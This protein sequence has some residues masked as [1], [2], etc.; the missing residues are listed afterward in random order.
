MGEPDAY[1][2]IEDKNGQLKRVRV[3]ATTGMVPVVE[4]IQILCCYSHQD[5][6]KKTWTR[7][8]GIS[9]QCNSN[10]ACIRLNG[11][12]QSMHCLPIPEFTQVITRAIESSHGTVSKQHRDM[13]DLLARGHMSFVVRCSGCHN[14]WLLSPSGVGNTEVRWGRYMVDV[15][16][17][18][19]EGGDPS[20]IVEVLGTSKVSKQ[21]V[22]AL[23]K[24]GIPWCEVTI[25]N[26][27]K[28]I[29]DGSNVV[30]AKRGSVCRQCSHDKKVCKQKKQ[31]RSKSQQTIMK[32]MHQMQTQV[33]ELRQQL[34]E[35]KGV[36]A[37]FQDTQRRTRAPKEPPTGTFTKRQKTLTVGLV[38]S[39]FNSK[40][41]T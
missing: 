12:G 31:Y 23:N 34:A 3:D 37:S 25:R 1:M 29:L 14:D 7:I 4:A 15:A 20:Q 35:L 19:K 27:N 16:F 13:Q 41:Y 21:K 26:A 36:V 38:N 32:R 9:P 11:V 6:A 28:A 8:M 22:E 30:R 24:S 39:Y 5:S 2:E 40:R 10:L 17:A 33:I 18:N